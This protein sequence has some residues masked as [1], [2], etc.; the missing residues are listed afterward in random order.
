MMTRQLDILL[1]LG[2]MTTYNE[3]VQL[4]ICNKCNDPEVT[5]GHWKVDYLRSCVTC[6]EKAVVTKF[7]V[8]PFPRHCHLFTVCYCLQ[9]GTVLPVGGV[10]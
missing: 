9:S 2:C 1:I 4:I 5:R 6:H 8:A 3:S 7:L 10:S